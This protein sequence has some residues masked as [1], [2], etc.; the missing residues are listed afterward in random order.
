MIKTTINLD[1]N[2][3]AVY[4]DKNLLV[5]IKESIISTIDAVLDIKK[6][7][8]I[9]EYDFTCM[10]LAREHCLNFD[11]SSYVVE[12]DKK[13]ISEDIIRGYDI[14][15]WTLVRAERTNLASLVYIMKSYIENGIA[16]VSRPNKYYFPEKERNEAIKNSE[17]AVL[18]DV[19]F[20]NEDK[21]F[22]L[23]NK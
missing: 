2:Q 7:V 14:I 23:K 10:E 19:H 22:F 21:R 4:I 9:N 17:E 12:R 3:N 16:Q 20:R 5:E 18:A 15:I 6:N 8:L 1:P 11:V 13:N